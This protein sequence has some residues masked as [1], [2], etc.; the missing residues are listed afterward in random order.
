MTKDN[1]ILD[2]SFGFAVRMVKLSL[3]KG[4]APFYFIGV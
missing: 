2:K 4:F 1:V 3:D